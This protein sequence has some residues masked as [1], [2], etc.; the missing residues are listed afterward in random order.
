MIRRGTTPT[1]TFTLPFGQDQIKDIR[2][3]YTQDDVEIVVKQ[4]DDCTFNG[5]DCIVSLTQVETFSFEEG[6]ADIQIRIL[7]T[8]D[9]VLNSDI[10]TRSVYKSLNEEVLK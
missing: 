2:I 6:K 9:T 4:L 5:N 10:I 3:S 7:T 1:H 8:V